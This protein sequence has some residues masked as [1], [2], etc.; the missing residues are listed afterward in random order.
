M[1]TRFPGARIIRMILFDPPGVVPVGAQR[2]LSK[3]RLGAEDRLL[4][5]ALYLLLSQ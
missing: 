4:E 2:D 5:I 3:D 1:I